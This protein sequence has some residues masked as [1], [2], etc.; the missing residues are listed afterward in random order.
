MDFNLVEKHVRMFPLTDFFLI[1]CR[2]LNLLSTDRQT[3]ETPKRL[4]FSDEHVFSGFVFCSLLAKFSF[5]VGIRIE[6][7]KSLRFR[8][9]RHYYYEL[10]T[11]V[12]MSSY[13]KKIYRIS[14]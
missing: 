11:L 4:T 1:L 6:S 10:K 9:R 3:H 5:L 14:K 12:S 2:F 13:L 8:S 7:E